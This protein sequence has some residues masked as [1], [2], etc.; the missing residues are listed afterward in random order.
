VW[1]YNRCHLI[2]LE[3]SCSCIKGLARDDDQGGGRRGKEGRVPPVGVLL[4]LDGATGTF[5]GPADLGL[6]LC[7]CP[8]SKKTPSAQPYD[9][10]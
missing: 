2:L 10:L 9:D 8:S 1:G 5:C 4:L 6:W 7:N 3:V